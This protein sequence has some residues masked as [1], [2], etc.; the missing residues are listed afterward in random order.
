MKKY[1]K[2]TVLFLC[3]VLC[4]S[5]FV[6]CGDGNS[7]NNSNANTD[8]NNNNSE[9]G[10]KEVKYAEEI[11]VTLETPIGVLNFHSPAGT[12]GPTNM[13]YRMIYDTLVYSNEDGT[14]SPMLAKE[15]ETDDWQHI[16]FYLRDDVYFHNGEK[17]TA[18]DVVY[19]WEQGL[20]AMGTTAYDNWRHV[21]SINVIDD[22]KIEVKLRNVNVDIFHHLS[23]IMAGIINKKA[24]EEDPEKGYHIGTGA[25]KVKEFATNDRVIFERNDNYWAELP[26]T[27]TQIWRYIPETS[28]RTIM[29][30]N[31]ESHVAFDIPITDVPLFKSDTENFNVI[32]VTMNNPYVLMFNMTDPIC[33]DINFR[34]AVALALDREEIALFTAGEYAIPATEDAAIWGRETEFRATHLEVYPKNLDKAAEYL[35]ASSYNGQEVE[36]VC[37]QGNLAKTSEAIQYQL[38]SIGIKTKINAM[39]QPSF[40]SYTKWA[41]NKAQMICWLCLMNLNPSGSPRP[42]FYPG[43]NNNRARYDNPELANLLDQ[44]PTLTDKAKR[45]EVLHKVQEM[46]Y[47]DMPMIKL[48]WYTSQCVTAKGVG[49]FF[50]PSS[51][52]HDMRYTYMTVE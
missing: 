38:Q 42:N 44:A 23:L 51:A 16:T 49:G 13:A 7:D 20:N 19:T 3:L 34:R 2:F 50:L 5:L 36:I 24:I 48:Y 40:S 21:E 9:P 18:A 32:P 1:L 25:Y 11:T 27:K 26:K 15:W 45:T 47:E 41:D 4:L 17:F 22:Y 33:G 39:D 31:G 10:P 6:A 35:A 37:P 52:M 29:L 46:I 8:T 12:G 43:A 14:F 30:Q 28:S